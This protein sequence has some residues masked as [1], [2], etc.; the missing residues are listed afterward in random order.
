MQVI[1]ALVYDHSAPNDVL[2]RMAQRHL[3]LRQHQVHL[4]NTMGVSL[5]ISHIASMMVIVR[6]ARVTMLLTRQMEMPAGAAC[7]GCTAITFF[8]NMKTVQ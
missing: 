2:W 7:I 5:D 4:G 3:M 8:M 1:R 6:V